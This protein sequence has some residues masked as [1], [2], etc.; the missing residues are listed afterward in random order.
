MSY[1]AGTERVNISTRTAETACAV[2][3]D[4]EPSFRMR[5]WRSTARSW[6]RATCPRLFWNLT[7]TRFG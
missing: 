4:T 6:S 5:R 1:G 3:E 2:F 7:A